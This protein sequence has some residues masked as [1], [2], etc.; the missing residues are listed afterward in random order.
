[1]S[2]EPVSRLA[3]E[4]DTSKILEA[5]VKIRA[6]GNALSKLDRKARKFDTEK[7][8]KNATRK[9]KTAIEKF[10]L[11]V[12][13]I[14]VNNTPIGSPERLETDR[15]YRRL[16]ERRASHYG[17]VPEVGFH[18]GAW[19]YSETKNPQFNPEI[20]PESTVISEFRSNFRANY[21]I[22]DTF[23][24]AATGPAFKYFQ[25]GFSE[26]FGGGVAA[27]SLNQIA[28]IYSQAKIG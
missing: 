5:E 23:Y 6:L 11:N 9:M 28:M 2:R 15:G 3:I 16:Y 4:I 14:L 20:R 21:E 22:G 26:S 12:A 8:R 10:S 7:F 19:V 27:P 17:I 24:V 13:Q 1:M 25:I 18:K